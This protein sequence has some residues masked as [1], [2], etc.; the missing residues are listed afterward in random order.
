MARP[1][2]PPIPEAQGSTPR[3]SPGVPARAKSFFRYFPVSERDRQWGLYITTTGESRILPPA[4]FYP[5]PGHPEPYRSVWDPGRV[6]PDHQLVYISKGSGWFHAKK[7]PRRRIE[8]GNVMLLFPGVWHRYAPDPETGWDEHWIG[9][10]GEIPR[11]LRRNGFFSIEN[12]VLKASREDELLAIFSEIMEAVRT[13]QPALQ[14][15]LAGATSHMLGL[16]YSAQQ[17]PSPSGDRAQLAVQT[18]IGRMHA[19]LDTK[20]DIHTLVQELGVSYSWFRRTFAQHTGLSPHQY[21][22]ELRLLRARNLLQGAGLTVKEAAHQTGFEDEHYFCRLFQRKTGRTPTEW[23]VGA[24]EK[25]ANGLIARRAL[26][27]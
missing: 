10:E 15:I 8:A 24:G 22:L 26:S 4:P 19:N 25:A 2:S 21:H 6:L 12:P 20:L 11:R 17:T 13:N 16:L 5:P 7:Q 23:R 18:A 9:F 27:R 3:P 1:P 14:Q